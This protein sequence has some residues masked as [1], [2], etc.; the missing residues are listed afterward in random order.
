MNVFDAA[1]MRWANLPAG[2]WPALDRTIHFVANLGLLKGG[3]VTAAIWGL[4][5][6]GRDPGQARRIR[7][8]LLVTFAAS[9]GGEFLARVLAKTLPFRLRPFHEPSLGFRLPD[10]V[11]A[12]TL[13]HWSSFPSDHAVFFGALASG[14]LLVSRRLGFLAVGYVLLVI[15]SPRVYLGYH[16]PTDILAGLL[17]GTALA[18]AANLAAFRRLAGIVLDRAEERPALFYCAFFLFAFQTASLFQDTRGIVT[19]LR[20]MLAG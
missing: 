20:E 13:E 3:I 17:L 16:Y 7:C 10:G 9:L 15:L 6:S 14:I 19:F 2:Q 12:G 4:W 5:F 18:V 8:T 11:P 1:V